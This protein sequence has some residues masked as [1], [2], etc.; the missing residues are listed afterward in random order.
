MCR[1]TFLAVILA[2]V[3]LVE[4]ATA[5]SVRSELL[6]ST[7]WLARHLENPEVVVVHVSRDRRAYDQGHVPG[8]RFLSWQAVATTRNGVPNE[9]PPFP[10]LV[11]TARRLGITSR[12]RIVLYDDDGGLFAARA[13]VALDYLGLGDQA[14]L[15]DGHLKKWKRE[16]RPL[17]SEVPRVRPSNLIARPHPE[18]VL[19]MGVVRDLVSLQRQYRDSSVA[20]VDA[21]PPQ[22][23]S[24]S[25]PGEGVRRPGHIPGARNVPWTE[26]LVDPEDNPVLRPPEELLRLYQSAGVDPGDLVVPYCRTGGQ[27]SHAYFVLKYLGFRPRLYDGSFIE[28]SADLDNPVESGQR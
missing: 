16:G 20:F 22:A 14:A 9:L 26:H 18:V 24:G 8:A 6:V 7:D 15:L 19:S 25:R 12:S 21:R 11:E 17:S 28:W 23:F 10:D 1:K 5:V 27:A 13:Y 4:S 2:A 3:G